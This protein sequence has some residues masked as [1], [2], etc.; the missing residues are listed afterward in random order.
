RRLRLRRKDTDEGSCAGKLRP[1]GRGALASR[2][3]H[4]GQPR[5]AIHRRRAAAVS[6]MPRNIGGILSLGLL[7]VASM[8][9]IDRGTHSSIDQARTVVVRSAD[10]W[11]ALWRAHAEGKPAPPV[12]FA[13]ELAVGVFLGSRPTA[14]YSVEIVGA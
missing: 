8:R 10:E 13:R 5:G 7:A 11:S 2:L 3:G 14:G 9:T 12:D 4:D 1:E 6:V